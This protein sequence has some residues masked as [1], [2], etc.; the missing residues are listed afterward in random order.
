MRGFEVLDD[1]PFD[2]RK[3]K[4]RLAE[5]G[6]RRVTV[7]KRGADIDPAAL[8]KQWNRQL[9]KQRG[10][11]RGERRGRDSGKSSPAASGTP[12]GLAQHQVTGTGAKTVTDRQ[13]GAG[14]GAGTGTG[15]GAGI[16]ARAG[17]S[18]SKGTG[19]GTGPSAGA[20]VEPGRTADETI[21]FVTRVAGRHRAII[22]RRA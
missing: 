17:A 15:A 12:L 11:Q 19:T 8:A 13:S 21:V 10:K 5:L 6:V 1:L 4:M 16:G 9:C 18:A 3:V 20:A 14:T 7:K 22:A 2:D